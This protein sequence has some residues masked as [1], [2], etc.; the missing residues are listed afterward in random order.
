MVIFDHAQPT[1]IKSTFNFCESVPASKKSLYSISSFLSYSQFKSPVTRL[2]TPI[3]DHA[4]P[5]NFQSPFN[6]WEFVP[7]MQK[8]IP[9]L[10]SGDTVNLTVQ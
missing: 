6:L 10:H 7:P 9:S 1:L 3:F 5:K 8:I 2:T 4:H